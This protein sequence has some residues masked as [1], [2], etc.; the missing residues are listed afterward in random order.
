MM[1]PSFEDE[2]KI[3]NPRATIEHELLTEIFGFVPTRV[4]DDLFNL[5]NIIFYKVMEGTAER[6][7]AIRPDKLREIN[8]ALD[9]YE[10]IVETKL[11]QL[12]NILQQ[13][14][15]Q[16]TWKIPEHLDI[17]FDRHK[18]VD[19]TAKDE[20]VERLDYELE[21]LRAK[22]VAQKKFKAV[23]THTYNNLIAE[24]KQLDK[25][26]ED[27]KFLRDIANEEK[28]QDV[29]NTL[30]LIRDQ[31]VQL[32]DAVINQLTLDPTKAQT[33]HN[34]LFDSQRS[35]YLRSKIEAQL[36]ELCNKN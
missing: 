24:N 27:M 3:K 2:L 20:D 6:L 13:Y 34:D 9:K 28:V 35:R 32:Q 8:S 36:K 22:I 23:L 18:D 19:F 16:G 1:G 21:E 29:Q 33:Q 25:Q 26:L 10:R 4:L 14:M 30:K 15:A 11:D 17:Q 7:T 12:F 31:L 5:A